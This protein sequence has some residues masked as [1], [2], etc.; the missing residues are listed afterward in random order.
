VWFGRAVGARCGFAAAVKEGEGAG[1]LWER[2]NPGGG[3]VA[4]VGVLASK[5]SDWGKAR[6]DFDFVVYKGFGD[7]LF[8]GVVI[9][10]VVRNIWDV[11][12]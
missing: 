12:R 2:D 9:H 8:V 1:L 6:S 5:A 3:V 11:I 4:D 7:Q 10:G